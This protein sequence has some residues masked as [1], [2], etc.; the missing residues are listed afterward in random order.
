MSRFSRPARLA[1]AV[2]L[3]PLLVGLVASRAGAAPSSGVPRLNHVFV[4]VEE[5]HGF[6][7]V[8]GNPAAPNLN[9]LAQQFGVATS[10][11]GITHPSEPN[12]VALLGGSFFGIADDNAYW[13][14]L[15]N[16]PSLISQLDAAH[17]SWK[18][19]LDG[20]P[21]P[22]NQGICNPAKCNGA[23]DIDPLYASKHDGIQNFTTSLNAADWSRQVPIGQ[24]GQDLNS[25]NV[26]AFN[27][28]IPSECDDMH[29]DP[30]YCIDSG[31]PGDPQDQRLV[32]NGDH[33][34]GEL[35]SNITNASF[36]SKGNNAIAITFDEGDDNNGCCDANAPNGGGQV[37]TVVVTSH[38]PRGLRDPN[39]YNHYSLLSTIQHS[40]GLGCLANTC[41]T[42][43]VQPMTPLFVVTGS[44]A[45]SYQ[46]MK[47]PAFD[48]S[49]PTP[50]EP[51]SYTTSTP[52]S[53]GWTVTP[54]PLLGSSDNS[55]GAVAG[56]GPRD[57]WAVGNFLPDTSNS[58]QDATLSLAAHYNGTKWSSVP[59]PNVGPNY[60][61]L[62]GVADSAGQAWAV[63]VHV[64]QQYQDRALIESWDGHAWNVVD[65]PQPGSMRDLLYGA[66]ADSPSDVWA[67][68]E[69]QSS[70]G[71]FQTLVEHWDGSAWNVIPSPN[72]GETDNHL[73]GVDA[74][75][76]SDVWAVG[77]QLGTSAPDQALIEHWDGTAWSVVPTP[78]QGSAS[79]MLDGVTIQGNEAWAVGETDD[80]VQGAHPL[81]E[82]FRGGNWNTVTLPSA[83]S[84]W[85]DLWG[86]TSSNGQVWAAG[87]YVDP[88]SGNNETLLLQGNDSG[89]NVVNAPN[90]GSGSNILG[91]IAAVSGQVWAVGLYDQGGS[92]LTLTESHSQT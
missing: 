3:L 21:H 60:N 80:P 81:V 24:L 20:S 79:V 31:N 84:N 32:A 69:Q 68:G 54:S 56:S 5:N 11:F 57:V 16:Q 12:Y 4:I 35:V 40:F 6:S 36:W 89:W 66:S 65:S 53:D 43:N 28:V 72:P 7:D 91:G 47:H 29:G 22:G 88:V 41:D 73:Y 70:D 50:K 45:L 14:N 9:S 63:G 38:G 61:T 37:A 92:N 64:D 58:N 26:P 83:G 17:V 48:T 2:V 59:T 10:Y 49:S 55:F 13:T 15:I 19:Y 25:G 27:Y 52:S 30:P 74:V 71:N 42:D 18:A 90:P 87:T 85:T 67:V 39:P 46:V 86:V 51:V 76:P 44:P 33:Y 34:L 75:S 77:Q 82:E 23:P 8:I 62:F 1:C 78:A